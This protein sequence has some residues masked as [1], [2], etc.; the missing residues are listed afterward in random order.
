MTGCGLGFAFGVYQELYETIG[1][2]FQDAKPAAIDLIGTLSA[3]LMTLGAPVVHYGTERFGP[4]RVVLFGGVLFAISGIAASFGS[5]IWHFQLSQGFLQGCAACLTYIPAVTVSPGYFRERRALA[6]GI[7]TSGTG[8]GGMVWAPLIRYLISTIGYRQTL[9]TIGTISS[10]IITLSAFVLRDDFSPGRARYNVD[11]KRKSLIQSADFIS[12]ASGTALQAAA[13]MIPMYFMSSYARTL[14]YTTVAGA[15][16]IALSNACNSGGKIIIGYHADRMGRLNAL[17]L[18]TLV[19]SVATF[20]I[21]YISI[22]S[23]DHDIHRVLF[24]AYACIYGATAGA[25]VSLFPT[26]LV[27]QFGLEKFSRVNGLLYMIRGI[28]TLF[29]TTLGAKLVGYGSHGGEP[30]FS[31]DFDKMFI[32]VGLLLCGATISVGWARILQRRK[33]DSN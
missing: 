7:I 25:Y 20:G 30:G 5:R 32:F 17:V 26:A 14:G 6:M 12:H 9:W 18:S 1:G 4:R 29:G 22:S 33:N 28:G 24:I 21:C 8:F 2:P 31:S 10:A 3:S 15:N 27:E 23:T 16:I 13:Y 19:S 11:I